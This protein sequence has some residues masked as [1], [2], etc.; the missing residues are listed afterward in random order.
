MSDIAVSNS[1]CLIGF[2]RIG[3]M[4]LLAQ[5]FDSL[6]IPPAVQNELGYA[7]DW[8]VV[9]PVQNA[10]MVQILKTQIDDGEAEA[11][12]LAIELNDVFVILDDKKARRVA[13]TLDLK[14]IGAVGILLRAK[15]RGIIAEIKPI[16]DDLNRVNFRV[17]PTLY[18]QALVLANEV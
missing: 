4:N 15:N 11:I 8:L 10:G 18:R 1:A 3:Q 5:S 6:L 2:E 17:S 9:K 12:A 7:L 14:I 16:L 13:Q